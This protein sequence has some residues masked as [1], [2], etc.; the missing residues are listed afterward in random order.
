MLIIQDSGYRVE[1]AREAG[2]LGWVW[3]YY[4]HIFLRYRWQGIGF[5]EKLG[6]S[7]IVTR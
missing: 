6:L 1:G 4:V 3:K 7:A 2:G 5:L